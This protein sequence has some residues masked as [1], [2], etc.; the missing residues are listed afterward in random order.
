MDDN[1]MNP[2]ILY[3]FLSLFIMVYVKWEDCKTEDNLDYNNPPYILNLSEEK[4]SEIIANNNLL[5]E[6]NSDYQLEEVEESDP[7]VDKVN[8]LRDIT[9]VDLIGYSKI[10]F[11]VSFYSDLN[12]ENGFGN[13]TATGKTLGDGMI[14]NNFLE[15]GTKVYIEGLGLKTVE[16]RGS[17]KYFNAIDKVDVFVP[18]ING[19]SDSE[20]YKRVNNLG[21]KNI[22][23]YILFIGE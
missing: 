1:R 5:R 14:A 3:L 11:E 21:R 16:D 17:K 10:T 18:R 22:D 20:Y 15:F 7:I 12:C 4:M 13:I 8:E 6:T 19:E 9:G 23:G 2:R